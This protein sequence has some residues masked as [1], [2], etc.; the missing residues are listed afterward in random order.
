MPSKVTPRPNAA[1]AALS[2]SA[3]QR[4]NSDRCGCLPR[5]SRSATVI[6]S[7]AI[8]D[9][10]SGRLFR[11]NL[12]HGNSVENDPAMGDLHL[13]MGNLHLN[14]GNPHRNMDD[15]RLNMGNPHLNMGNPHSNMGNPH[16]NMGN[17]HLNMGNPHRNMG[18]PHLNM[19]NP[20][21]SMLFPFEHIAFHLKGIGAEKARTRGGRFIV[22]Q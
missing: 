16:L 5:P 9:W 7:G 3:F 20:H 8:G 15:P 17:P 22:L 18:N 10:G 6:P 12:V 11:G 14:M 4:E 19:G 2:S 13:N 1:A 21:Q